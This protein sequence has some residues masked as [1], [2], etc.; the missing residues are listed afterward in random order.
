MGCSEARAAFP[1]QLHEEG[2]VLIFH[3]GDVPGA[4]GGRAPSMALAAHQEGVV[5]EPA[6]LPHTGTLGR[7]VLR[8]DLV[9]LGEADLETR[10][11]VAVEA[12]EGVWQTDEMVHSHGE[13]SAATRTH[14]REGADSIAPSPLASRK[15]EPGGE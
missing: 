11:E 10:L 8:T 6:D 2:R 12:G 15:E 4:I 7:A 14:S 13:G 1:G 3:V 5:G 9:G